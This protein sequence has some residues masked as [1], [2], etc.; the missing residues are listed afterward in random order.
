M[1][2]THDDVRHIAALARLPVSEERLPGLVAE[3]NGILGHMDVLARVDTSADETIAGKG[4][5][6]ARDEGPSVPLERPIATFAPAERDGFFLVPRL[7]THG[8]AGA[9]ADEPHA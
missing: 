6:L 7:A 8:D 2:V 9:V 5:R 4:M 3:L 1:A